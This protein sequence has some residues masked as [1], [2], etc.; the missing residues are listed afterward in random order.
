MARIGIRLSPLAVQCAF[1]ALIVSCTKGPT[2]PRP[3]VVYPA[4]H[5]YPSWAQSGR[6]AYID[7]G[8]VCVGTDG[9]YQ[10]DTSLAG[11]FLFDP[12]TGRRKRIASQ[13]TAVA[14]NSDNVTLAYSSGTRIVVADTTGSELKSKDIGTSAVNVSWSPDRLWLAWD[15][16]V[17]QGGLWIMHVDSLVPRR[18][19][20]FCSYPSWTGGSDS[21]VALVGTS[22]GNSTYVVTI[23]A[24]SAIVDTILSVPLSIYGM[25]ANTA[26]HVAY[27]AATTRSGLS[28]LYRLNLVS[29]I[30]TQLTTGGGA[31]P[32]IRPQSPDL[33]YIRRARSAATTDNCVWKLNTVTFETTAEVFPWP[34]ACH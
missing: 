11:L 18:L 28:Q 22:T 9:V 20:T 5:G 23:A 2:D 31:Q 27:L 32:A 13:A 30:T 8:I 21:L 34:S 3:E 6:L 33:A 29:G 19:S 26:V 12:P 4:R 1:V 7:Y 14:W 15:Q 25:T 10:R 17:V 24:A 16:V